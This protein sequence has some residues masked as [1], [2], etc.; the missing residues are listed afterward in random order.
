M[1]RT[2]FICHTEETLSLA[3]AFCRSCLEAQRIPHIVL[4]HIS[5]IDKLIKILG[6][7]RGPIL[8]T[9]S[10]LE[11]QFFKKPLLPP[12]FKQT[13]LDTYEFALDPVVREYLGVQG[14]EFEV[15]TCKKIV[16]L[17]SQKHFVTFKN[18]G[19]VQIVKKILCEII[20]GEMLILA[21]IFFSA[22]DLIHVAL[23]N[24][25]IGDAHSAFSVARTK[26]GLN[27]LQKISNPNWTCAL[28]LA[29]EKPAYFNPE[30]DNDHN[31][32][33]E[34]WCAPLFFNILLEPQ[35][36]PFFKRDWSSE[37]A[38]S[39][40]KKKGK[41]NLNLGPKRLFGAICFE[42]AN[43]VDSN[44]YDWSF[45]IWT[46]GMPP[47]SNLHAKRPLILMCSQLFI[48]HELGHLCRITKG[49]TKPSWPP[50]LTNPENMS[51][52]SKIFSA[53]VRKRGAHLEQFTRDYHVTHSESNSLPPDLYHQ[54]ETANLMEIYQLGQGRLWGNLEEFYNIFVSETSENAIRNVLGIPWRF[55]HMD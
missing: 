52:W 13:V 30:S 17:K 10:L 48:I 39:L 51:E 33:A 49:A 44:Q 4:T 40:S 31:M 27:F 55:G 42:P 7:I 29:K 18:S 45:A 23:M 47:L 9:K 14:T 1:Q 35:K 41:E 37:E 54:K 36:F 26:T 21:Q 22:L 15:W 28:Y 20:P 50:Y 32:F 19:N 24:I 38:Y 5:R 2:C 6:L 53:L 16:D 34:L 12:M 43:L 46:R 25:A 8:S 3:C 11:T